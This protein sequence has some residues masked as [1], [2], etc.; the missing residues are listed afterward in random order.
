LTPLTELAWLMGCEFAFVPGLGGHVPKHDLNMETTVPGVFIA[1]DISGV[2]EASTALEEGRLAGTACAESLGLLERDKA[3]ALKKAIWE[4][5]NA[6]RTGSFGDG[7]RQAKEI[8]IGL[9]AG[10]RA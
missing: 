10:G 9:S 8:L 7:R 6:L 2:E 3:L 5:M 1:G 4:R